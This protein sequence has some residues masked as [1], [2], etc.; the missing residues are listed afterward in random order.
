MKAGHYL[1]LDIVLLLI[2]KM[3][4]TEYTS[5]LLVKPRMR[6]PM[7]YLIENHLINPEVIYLLVKIM[8]YVRR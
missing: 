1:I 3:L 2:W 6:L 4:K 8:F 7:S 5:V